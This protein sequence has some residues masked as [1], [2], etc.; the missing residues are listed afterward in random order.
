M[1]V[2]TG[3]SGNTGRIIAQ[4]LL[5][6]GKQVKLITRKKTNVQ[7]LLDAGATL[8]EGELEDEEFLTEAFTG[9]KQFMRLIPPKWDLQE[10]WRNFQR[11]VLLL[12]SPMHCRQLKCHML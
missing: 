9:A 10:P 8:A 6:E 1:Y 4:Q 5:K 12:L 2:I 11:R 3:A 7:E